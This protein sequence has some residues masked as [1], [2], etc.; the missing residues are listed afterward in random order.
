MTAIPAGFQLHVN[1]WENDGDAAQTQIWSGIKIKEDVKFL[2]A[3][4]KKFT[5][6]GRDKGLGNS[7]VPADVLINT[8][9]KLL[10]KHT[11]ISTELRG[12]F[13]QERED[14]SS[15]SDLVERWHD[16]ICNRLLGYPVDE[17]YNTNYERFCRV[18]SSHRVFYFEQPAVDVTN[19]FK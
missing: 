8:I 4:V 16:L 15:P 1:T 10:A 7:G 6:N 12:F 17:F 2:V 3:L 14:L 11:D 18:Y 19:Q 13:E 5:S 9:E